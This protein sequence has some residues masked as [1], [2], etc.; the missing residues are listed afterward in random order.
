MESRADAGALGGCSAGHRRRDP[1]RAIERS[2]AVVRAG[3][4]I[5]KEERDLA[6]GQDAVGDGRVLD[7]GARSGRDVGEL[8]DVEALA[9]EVDGE[10]DRRSPGVGDVCR[11][12]TAVA[13]EVDVRIDRV[14]FAAG[15]RL[16]ARRG[17]AGAGRPTAAR[18]PVAD[19]RRPAVAS[20]ARS[21]ASAAARVAAAAAPSVRVEC[22]A[23]RGAA[24]P[25]K[26]QKRKAERA[27]TGRGH[28]G[29]RA[30][31]GCRRVSGPSGFAREREFLNGRAACRRLG[32]LAS[33]LRALARPREG[34]R[35]SAGRAP[36]RA[37]PTEVDLACDTNGDRGRRHSHRRAPG[38][39]C[40]RPHRG[41]GG[42]ARAAGDRSGA[43]ADGGGG[44]AAARARRAERAAEAQGQE[45]AGS[46]SSA[47]SRTPSSSRCSPR[48]SSPSS[49]A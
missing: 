17:R 2:D 44:G 39:A 24:T 28:A 20:R 14:V 3:D 49:T 27:G 18:A 16:R 32:L 25:G 11:E 19:E 4:V 10:R 48:P 40:A 23:P 33:L 47:S 9:L 46:S 15:V 43:R 34:S 6:R 42:A 29:V 30:Q 21:G 12:A 45:P 5:E 35:W 41:A 31:A 26:E 8:R 22:V 37:A 7:V 1:G 36:E 38:H 13:A